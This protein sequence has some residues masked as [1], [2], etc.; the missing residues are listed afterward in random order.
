M[1]RIRLT[2]STCLTLTPAPNPNS[3]H[4]PNPNPN[5]VRNSYTPAPTPAPH[6]LDAGHST[7]LLRLAPRDDEETAALAQCTRRH[8]G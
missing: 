5:P 7:H 2:S 6:L 1:A 3:I 4:N 8:L